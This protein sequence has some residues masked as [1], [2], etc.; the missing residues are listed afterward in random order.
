MKTDK[1]LAVLLGICLLLTSILIYVKWLYPYVSFEQILQVITSLTPDVIEENISLKDYIIG[2]SF[3]AIAFPLIL[4]KTTSNQQ[5]LIIII[6]LIFI[7]YFS[8]FAEYQYYM[9]K[10][11][12]LYEDEYV[13]PSEIEFNF[14]KK[15]RNLVLIIMESFEQNFSNENY[16]S[17]N[18]IPNLISLQN[19]N[20]HS[21]NNHQLR[22][23]AASIT[24]L[25]AMHCG[26]PY[27]LSKNN[28]IRYSKYFLPN[29]IC[30]PE[31]LKHN[32]Y[33]TEIIKAAD[34]KYTHADIFAKTHGYTKVLGKDELKKL[35]PEFNQ[36]QHQGTFDG[37]NDRAL[38]TAAKKELQKM[39]KNE[40]FV[41]TLF[42]LDTHGRF[43]HL[44]KSCKAE[45]NDLR[46]AFMCSDKAVYDFITWLKKQPFAKNTTIIVLGDHKIPIVLSQKDHSNHGIYN[47]FL[48]LPQGL[49]INQD[50]QFTTFD[51]APTILEALQIKLSPRSFGLGRSIFAES[52]TLIEKLG[53]G[54]YYQLISYSD[55]YESLTTP[56][57]H[58]T[59][60]NLYTLG[61][62]ISGKDV[63]NWTDYYE[64]ILNKIY[65]DEFNFK[66]AS[67]PQTNLRAE[68][69]FE[70]MTDEE[71]KIIFN[72]NGSD[73]F[74]CDIS[75]KNFRN[76]TFEIDKNL[77]TKDNTIKLKIRKETKESAND[78]Y[79]D[80]IDKVNAT[81]I[82]I[83]VKDLVIKQK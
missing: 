71:M 2:L 83:V 37:L 13:N 20:N 17:Q 61:K 9:T 72:V 31:I 6:D 81:Y 62:K 23:T 36:P 77:V 43:Y 80:K 35:Y 5:V 47:V 1:I 16:Y 46:D 58:K 25:T 66:L 27:R 60:Y 12:T 8:G 55:F 32:G 34:I 75:E 3:F 52:K 29:A 19:E 57:E 70:T 11:T 50:K 18:L 30:F 69:K 28:D 73:V 54:F 14:P 44:D 21:K 38:F 63:L 67:K 39:A 40:P 15:K 74:V 65:V 59:K 51:L 26:I 45:F 68:L 49:S 48:N 56:P 64:E 53:T 79:L 42:S 33:H 22:L 4:W 76:I 10:K 78:L 82:G 24:A 7:A 41:L